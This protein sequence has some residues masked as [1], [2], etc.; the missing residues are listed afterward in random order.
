MNRQ[1]LLG[2]LLGVFDSIFYI[3]SLVFFFLPFFLLA[4]LRLSHL[5]LEITIFGDHPWRPPLAMQRWYKV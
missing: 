3:H 5:K 1:R 2:P 4:Q